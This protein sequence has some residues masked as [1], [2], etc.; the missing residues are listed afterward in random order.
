MTHLR[1]LALAF[2]ALLAGCA[3]S[4]GPIVFGVAGPFSQPRGESMRLAAEL[5]R[6]EINAAGG[7]AGRSIELRFIDDSATTNGAV[8]AAEAFV[9]DP[10][11]IAVVGHLTSASTLAA[12]PIYDGDGP[13]AVISPS[14]SSPEISL[15]GAAVFRVCPSDLMHGAR[16]GE[17]ALRE[18]G[19]RR[20]LIL[21]HNDDYGRGVRSAFAD[22]FTALGGTVI[23]TDPYLPAM[24]SLRPYLERVIRGGGVDAVMIAGARA[25]AERIVATMDSLDLHV[26]VLGADGLA[27]LAAPARFGAPVFVSYAYHPSRA[28]ERN[29]SFLEAYAA[30]FE[31]RVPDH[32]GAAA[33]DIVHLL[34]RAV[35]EAGADREAV[36]AQLTGVGTTSD[37][38]EGVLGSIAFDPNGDVVAANVEIFGTGNTG[39]PVPQP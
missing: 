27:G 5:A 16:L 18:L 37:A 34:A 31:G 15:A 3:D 22:R 32:R 23:S 10:A 14:A 6:D 17:Y 20:V 35:G 26:P 11:V 24:P 12:A 25:E 19:A 30:R 29:R 33:Y 36:L 2:C 1:R 9:A 39:A 8:R 38:F 13:L 28:G 7:V 21:Y 4:G